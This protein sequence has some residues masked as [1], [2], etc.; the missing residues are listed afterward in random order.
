MKKLDY[1]VE[2]K[3]KHKLNNYFGGKFYAEERLLEMSNGEIITSNSRVKNFFKYYKDK[4]L[5]YDNLEIIKIFR[6]CN[7]IISHLIMTTK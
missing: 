7:F 4:I 5:S 1:Y 6:Y 3:N 2:I